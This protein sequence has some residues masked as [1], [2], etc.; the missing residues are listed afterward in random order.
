MLA[1]FVI[2]NDGSLQSEK[3]LGKTQT[4]EGRDEQ[5][6]TGTSGPRREVKNLKID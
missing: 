3:G 5:D 4:E 6:V 2:C 1:V